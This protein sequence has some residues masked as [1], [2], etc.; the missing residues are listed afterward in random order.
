[1]K[2]Q[3]VFLTSKGNVKLGDF[4]IAKILYRTQELA[5]T[6][7]GTPYYLSPEVI[8]RKPYSFYADICSLGVLLYEIF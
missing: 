5:R 8:Q 4:G 6:L 2:S 3:N 1:M 7:V